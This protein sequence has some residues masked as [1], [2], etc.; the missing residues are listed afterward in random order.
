M[1]ESP[2]LDDLAVALRERLAVI[3]DRDLFAR[4]PAL[5]L[6]RLRAASEAIT[7][8]Q[9]RLPPA[10][11]PQLSHYLDRCSY[12]KALALLENTH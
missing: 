6:E 2:L 9:S 1:L 3:A 7:S 10:V 4:E 12:D 8:I 5:H 11:D